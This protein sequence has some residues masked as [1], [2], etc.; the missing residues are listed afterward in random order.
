MRCVVLFF[1]FFFFHTSSFHLLLSFLCGEREWQEEWTPV[2]WLSRICAYA[3]CLSCPSIHL[4][5]RTSSGC[6]DLVV[7]VG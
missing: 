6:L 3:P 5:W 7:L 2:W 1:F 4:Q